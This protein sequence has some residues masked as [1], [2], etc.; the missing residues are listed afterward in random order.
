MT[1]P[2]ERPTETRPKDADN[3]AQPIDRLKVS[4]LPSDAVNI[5]VEGR[6]VVGPLQG[7]GKLW[8]KTYRVRLSGVSVTPVEVIKAWK[9]NFAGFWPEGNRF[10]A[11]FTGIAPGDVA[12]LNLAAPGGVT[13]STG[14]MVIYAD[15][16]SFTFMTPEGHMFPGWITF[17]AQQQKETTVVQAQVLVRANDPLWEIVMRLYGFRREDEF[18]AHTLRSLASRFGVQGQPQMTAVRVDPKLQWSQASNIWHNA[19]IRSAIYAAAAPLR[20]VRKP[21]VRH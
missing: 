9:A 15:D 1:T 5:N 14:V 6:H 10:Y 2:S 21:F 4:D 8:Q 17:S 16:E 7:F 11:P 3:W 19:A 18:W 20:W 12:V 13:L